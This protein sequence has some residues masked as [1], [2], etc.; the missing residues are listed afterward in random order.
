MRIIAE[1]WENNSNKIKELEN[2]KDLEHNYL[3][4]TGVT[5]PNPLAREVPKPCNC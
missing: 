5:I 4:P 3:K 1:N 2:S